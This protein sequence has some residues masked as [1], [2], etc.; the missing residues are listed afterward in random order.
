MKIPEAKAAA[1]DKRKSDPRLQCHKERRK[2]EN[3]I[4]FATL[5]D[6]CHQK[7]AELARHLMLQRENVK[8]NAGTEQ[9]PRAS[10]PQMAAAKFLEIISQFLGMT[11]EASAVS[12]YTQVKMIDAPRLLKL[13]ENECPEKRINIPPRQ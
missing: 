5:I 1:W 7:N 10:A 12:E 6:L 3:A 4:H 9:Y 2:K 13:P 11:G 8:A